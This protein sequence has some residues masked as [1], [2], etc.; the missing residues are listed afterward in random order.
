MD[1]SSLEAWETFLKQSSAE[2][3]AAFYEGIQAGANGEEP[4]LCG[5]CEDQ[6]ESVDALFRKGK[7]K[8]KGKRGKG[9]G[10]AAADSGKGS[11]SSGFSGPPSLCPSPTG[12]EGHACLPLVPQ[13]GTCHEGLPRQAARQ[14]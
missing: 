3:V 12:R 10:G 14:A 4:P 7:G 13:D 6:E 9:Q 5:T 1:V 11:Q 2:D 8:G